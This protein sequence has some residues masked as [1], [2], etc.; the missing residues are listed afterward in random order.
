MGNIERKSVKQKSKRSKFIL[1]FVLVPIVTVTCLAL[2]GYC[3]YIKTQIPGSQ[4][5][6]KGM[7]YSNVDKHRDAIEEFKKALKVQPEDAIIHYNIG[8][9]YFKL[10]EYGKSETSLKAAL[11]IKPDFIDAE[12]QMIIIRLKEALDLKKISKNESL[13]LEKFSEAE[14]MCGELLS[15]YPNLTQAHMLMGEIHTCQGFYKDAIDIYTK[16]ISLDSSL[17]D[18][19][20]SLAKL[21][22][23]EGKIKL[24]EQQC[25]KV[26]NTVDPDNYQ[27]QMLLSKIYDTNGK[28][29]EAISVLTQ[30]S[31]KNPDDMIVPAQLSVLYLK[32][33][34]F[35]E[36]YAE[37]EKVSML[38]PP[39]SLPPMVHFVKGSVLLERKDYINAVAQ[40]NEVKRRIPKMT[41]ARYFL[42]LALM[43]SGRKEQAISEFDQ[44][45]KLSPEFV[46]AKW[47]LANLYLEDGKLK[48]AIEIGKDILRFEPKNINVMQMIGMAY[49]KLG[50]LKAAEE[51][52]NEIIKLN[53]TVGDINMAYLNLKF[54]KL[55]KC[56]SQCEEIIKI[57]PNI[58]RVYDILGLA[59]IKRKEFEKAIKKFIKSTEIDENNMD[60]FLNLA[61]AYILTRKYTDAINTLDNFVS[62]NPEN[63]TAKTMLA[64][65]YKSDGK[66]DKAIELFENVLEIRHDYLP[67][68]TLGSL[69]LLNGETDKSLD[70]FNKTLKINA[71]NAVLYN[72]FAVAFQQ[73]KDFQASI[74]YSK[75]AIMLKPDTPLFRIVLTNLYTSIG[76]I[77]KAKKQLKYITTLNDNEKKEYA[78]LIDMCQVNGK[79][80]SNLTLALNKAII[81]RQN[82]IFK[83]AVKECENA[84]EIFPTNFIPKIFLADNYLSSGHKEKAIMI[85]NEIV[86][87]RP[88]FATSYYGLG[89]A[90]LLSEKQNQ[91]IAAYQNLVNIDRN[92]VSARLTLARL[93]LEQGSIDRAV[94]L[95]SEVKELDPE[96]IIAQNMLGAANFRNAKYKEAEKDLLKTLYSDKVTVEN[97]FNLAKIKFGEGDIDKCIEHCK[98]GLEINPV[99]IYLLN[100]L[101]MAYMKKGFLDLANGEFNKIIEINA[102]FVPAYINIANVKLRLRKTGVA[103]RLYEMAL[104]IEPENLD[105]KLGLAN[106]YIV[107]GNHKKA[108]DLLNSTKKENMKNAQI[109]VSLANSYM[110]IEN[111]KKAEIM[112]TEALKINPTNSVARYIRAKIYIKNE[113]IPAATNLL[114]SLLKDD[115]QFD[116][117]YTLGILYMDAGKYKK[118]IS[119]YK[120][121]LEIVPQN[122]TF[123]SNLAIN[124]LMNK[125]YAKANK[126]SLNA[127]DIKPTTT[128]SNLKDI[129]RFYLNNA[130]SNDDSI[131]IKLKEGYHLSRAIA[132]LNNKWFKRSLKE[133]DAILKILPD[134]KAVYN[135][136]ADILVIIGEYDKAI[137]ILKKVINI[138]PTS[139]KAYQ[140]LATIY[141]RAGRENDAE[142][143]LRKLLSI[144]PEDANVLVN[145]GVILQEKG[146]VDES[147]E[148]Y[149]RSIALRPSPVAYNNLAWLYTYEYKDGQRLDDA[150]RFAKKAKELSKD[151]IDILDTLG[152]AYYLSSKY[153]NALSELESAADNVPWNPTIRYHLGMVYYKKG[154]NRLALHEMK[155]AIQI[156][157]Q[158]P[159]ADNARMVI[160]EITGTKVGQTLNNT[161]LIPISD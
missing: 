88:A 122:T 152:W 55:S 21:Y 148:L 121:G 85:Y 144:A 60:A 13:V 44:V 5:L 56:I 47:S 96:N 114:E 146:M 26:L 138:D 68:F 20:V 30:V 51:Q 66:I 17:I 97:Y 74:E 49:I 24:A 33:S 113:D 82:G 104:S 143:E 40:L 59:Y 101:G 160:N 71:E 8:I 19:H 108:I 103:I 28:F 14:Q 118:A 57:N 22:L 42:A 84:V 41:E 117:A 46:L 155:K 11:K 53:P 93:L 140:K 4:A 139:K 89:K 70:L 72:E 79:K 31:K 150:I 99:D 120:Q 137:E 12:L 77:E 15:K 90:Y 38:S 133:Y 98:A 64:N 158:F 52:F 10:K 135:A 159:N 18:A 95:I 112:I 35:N 32:L 107:I 37:T 130:N 92:S 131:K 116:G 29:N 1:L 126:T 83:M 145:L 127:F 39:G 157:P 69:Y 109:Y 80:R 27:I 147:V 81:A 65:L 100:I 58:A 50:K 141:F 129:C 62:L 123:L 86:E 161:A 136:K 78:G 119:I 102:D 7:I 16:A 6:K 149:K 128:I 151:N 34:K 134:S 45:I 76:E 67:G 124:Y 94:K 106:A 153:D 23:Q 48:D 3:V 132:Y 75:K 125:E 2:I 156:N 43:E 61:N 142:I 73:N 54:G 105:A 9:S 110:A 111:Y 115:P 154:M 87:S 25:K 63:L 91:A 36:A